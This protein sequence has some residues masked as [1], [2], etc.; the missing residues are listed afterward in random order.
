MLQ[1]VIKKAIQR[2]VFFDVIIISVSLIPLFFSPQEISSSVGYRTSA[3]RANIE[4]WH[5]AQETW[6]KGTLVVS[7]IALLPQILFFLA[8][9]LRP[10]RRFF[11]LTENRL[12]GLFNS[13]FALF[14]LGITF[15]IVFIEMQLRMTGD[16]GNDTRDIVQLLILD[17]ALLLISLF[18][19][20]FP[21][22]RIQYFY[23]Y[24]TA[25]A[26]AN[27]DNWQFAQKYAGKFR[28]WLLGAVLLLQLI[29]FLFW[30]LMRVSPN[31]SLLFII[32]LVVFLVGSL[33]GLMSTERQ[34]KK[35]FG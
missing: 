22:K 7:A 4:N 24:K 8:R 3:A 26:M 31:F 27:R 18:L 34:L 19:F 9:M 10:L 6:A 12:Y 32:S 29:L 16:I 21:P 28:L 15:C 17:G 11:T 23:G 33:I 35:R 13:S 20:F 2:L 1:K 25:R 30:S 5:F 14:I